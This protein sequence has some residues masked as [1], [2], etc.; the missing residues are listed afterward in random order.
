VEPRKK[1]ENDTPSEGMLVGAQVI[2]CPK[3]GNQDLLMGIKAFYYGLP[4]R[5]SSS[6]EVSEPVNPA[7]MF[8]C[9]D[10]TCKHFFDIEDWLIYKGL[11]K[12]PEIQETKKEETDGPDSV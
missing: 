8:I 1:T 11:A 3:C 4:V 10:N 7:L 9:T 12:K 5:E 6:V 2:G